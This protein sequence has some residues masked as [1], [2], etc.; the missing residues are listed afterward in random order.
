MRELLRRMRAFLNEWRLHPQDW[1]QVLP[2]VWQILNQS[3]SPSI[4]NI[5]PD[6]AMTGIPAVSLVAQIVA[7]ETPL[8]VTSMAAVMQT[9]HDTISSTQASLVDLHK[10]SAAV[11]RKRGEQ[12]RDFVQSK[13]GVFIA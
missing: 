7:C 13:P 6:N 8:L 9:Q 3:S 1:E 10:N 2:T 11:N 4:G 5:S 12:E